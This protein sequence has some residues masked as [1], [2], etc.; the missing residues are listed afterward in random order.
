MISDRIRK[1]Y[2][3]PIHVISLPSG[4][5]RSLIHSSQLTHPLL[6]R[7]YCECYNN[8]AFFQCYSKCPR[9]AYITQAF[10]L[11][12]VKIMTP[13]PTPTK[14]S[15]LFSPTHLA[16]PR[17]SSLTIIHQT[18]RQQLTIR[19]PYSIPFISRPRIHLSIRRRRHRRRT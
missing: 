5:H 8:F 19:Q 9:Y 18:I 7:L 11:F 12:P 13:N 4:R 1:F 15:H 14:I 3:S 17:R 2:S 10:I 16:Q 6:P